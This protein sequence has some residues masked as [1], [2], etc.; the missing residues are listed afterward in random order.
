MIF[1]CFQVG[2]IVSAVS[3]YSAALRMAQLE[4]CGSDSTC[5]LSQLPAAI[6]EALKKLNIPL[7]PTTAPTT[8]LESTVANTHELEGARRRI[9]HQGKLISRKY[10]LLLSKTNGRVSRVS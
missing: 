3:V 10:D 6:S 4:S 9:N 7:S 5:D 1:F 8:E 2:F